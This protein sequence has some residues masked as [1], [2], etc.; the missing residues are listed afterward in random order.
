MTIA[1]LFSTTLGA[2][3]VDIVGIEVG[4]VGLVLLFLLLSGCFVVGMYLLWI[5]LFWI[6]G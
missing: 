3:V 4:P 2:F 6:A 5:F 1:S